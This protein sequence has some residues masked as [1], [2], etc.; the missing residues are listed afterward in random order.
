MVAAESNNSGLPLQSTLPAPYEN[1]KAILKPINLDNLP[2]DNIKKKIQA[3]LHEFEVFKPT[4][5]DKSSKF[6]TNK[7]NKVSIVKSQGFL[8]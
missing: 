8:C 5:D 1:P 7:I 6:T 2:D 4:R 3:R